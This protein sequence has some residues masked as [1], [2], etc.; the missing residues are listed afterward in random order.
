[1]LVKLAINGEKHEADVEPRL[2]LVHLIREV[3]RLTGTHIGC[4][5]SEASWAARLIVA[6]S[7]CAPLSAA[8]AWVALIGVRPTL[9][10]PIP[11]CAHVPF[12]ARAR[13]AA[14]A[15]VAKSPTFRP[16]LT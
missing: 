15:T 9:A 7:G 3:L 14:T 16:S 8:S 1:M 11:T 2:L 12:A 6:S 4:D 10:S 5:A 13:C